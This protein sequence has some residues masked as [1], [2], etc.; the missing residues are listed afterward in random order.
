MT[1]T[2]SKQVIV[3]I[4]SNYFSIGF[5]LIVGVFM[6]PFL[7]TKLGIEMYGI[8]ALANT[9]PSYIQ[10]FTTGLS[11]STTRF[12]AI[13]KEKKNLDDANMYFY[14]SYRSLKILILL[15]FPIII[16]IS[17]LTPKIFNVPTNSDVESQVLV[18]FVLMST[19]FNIIQAPFG[20]VY[21]VY[22]KFLEKNLIIIFSKLI[23]VCLFVSLFWYFTPKAWY[24]GIYQISISIISLVL[25]L[26]NYNRFQDIFNFKSKNFESSALKDLGKLGF[27]NSVNDVAALFFLLISQLLINQFLGVKESGYFGPVLLLT[28]LIMM[29]S[30]AISN[31]LMPIIYRDIAIEK[32]A[33][34]LENKLMLLSKM[35]AYSLGFP[36]FLI[37]VFAND[38][39]EV[40]LGTEF[41]KITLIVQIFLVSL[42]FG[43]I[44]FMPYTHFYRGLNKIKIPAIINLLFGIIN[45][46]LIVLSFYL[47]LGVLGVAYS[48][49]FTFGV[50]GVVFNV[51]YMAYVTKHNI[52]YTV[53][54]TTRMM[55]TL[56]LILSVFLI[57]NQFHINIG[58]K[59][60]SNCTFFCL[61]VLFF[62]FSN[63]EKQFINKFIKIKI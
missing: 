14:T 16:L 9:L 42:F 36:V 43:G 51:F 17:L 59:I 56:I 3:N 1:K 25:F 41:V 40:W 12:M 57:I 27:W 46:I 29:G 45:V 8:I 6:A 7:I 34:D 13:S 58:L 28:S 5:N 37:V 44:I 21:Q 2:N 22:H 61:M 30:G 38:V 48:F 20:S 63:L 53:R 49:G 11:S 19:L 60:L 24:V 50:R 10:I 35:L 33:F 15:L 47:N 4:I 18:F 54:K 39:L 26:K 31:V 23:S 62:G 52:F 32:G 55:F